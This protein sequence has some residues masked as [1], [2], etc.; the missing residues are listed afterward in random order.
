MYLEKI[1]NHLK[2]MEEIRNCLIEDQIGS[3]LIKE[4]LNTLIVTKRAILN[5]NVELNQRVK[6][7]IKQIIGIF[8]F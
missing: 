2:I 7:E 5:L 4:T 3:L 8:N 6:L 1:G